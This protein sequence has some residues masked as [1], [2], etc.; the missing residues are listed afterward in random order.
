MPLL[1]ASANEVRKYLG[2]RQ[3]P[4]PVV[5][6]GSM[7]PS[8][9]WEKSEGGPDEPQLSVVDEYRT[10]PRMFHRFAGISIFGKTY[11]HRSI[12]YGDM[13]TFQSEHTREIL[14]KEGKDTQSGFIKRAMGLP[15]DTLE[16]RD[17]YLLRNGERVVEPY[18]YRPRSTYGDATLSDCQLLTVP[19]GHYF[20][21]GDNRK[22]S[23]DSRGELGF[24]AEEDISFILPYSDQKLYQSL[25]RDTSQDQD[26]AGT[27]TLSSQEFYRLVREFR[28]EQNLPPLTPVRSL[29]NSAKYKASAILEGN[30]DYSLQ[31]ALARAG[32][33]NI[34]TSELSIRGR[35]TAPE[36]LANILF[37][38][39]TKASL[40]DSRYTDIGI[41]ALSQDVNSCPSEVV[42]V[43]LGGYVPA[44]YDTSVIESWQNLG[45][46]LRQV[47]PSWEQARDNSDLDQVKLEELLTI[48]RRRLELA[49]EVS[50]AMIKGEWLTD[51]QEGRIKADQDDS[52]RAKKLAE[53]L[54][55]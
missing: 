29:E 18:I 38:D 6:T 12:G 1:A 25:W 21:L 5:G 13:V 32:Y 10:T 53:E 41:Y 51:T 26:L 39:T 33:R 30:P 15:G 20:V 46:S 35:Y 3:V 17:G 31:S 55:E 2:V 34:A 11:L 37:F 48:L 16:L 42:V 49:D 8:L 45:S 44:E 9:F 19:D 7:Y 43:H 50:Q 28:Q 4:V 14:E 36:L 52:A 24:V 47:I 22:T 27:P 54:N 40:A 23:S